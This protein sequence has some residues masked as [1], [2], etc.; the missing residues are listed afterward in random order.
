MFENIFRFISEKLSLTKYSVQSVAG[1]DISA[2]FLLA[3][4]E[5]KYFVKMNDRPFARRV[6][7]EEQ[8][9]LQAI[10]KTGTIN[11]PHV[12]LTDEFENQSFIV[13]EYIRSTYPNS[14]DFE[15]LGIQ[16]AQLHRTTNE[17]FGFS[18][19]NFIGRLPQS[20]RFH[21]DWSEFYWQERILPQLQLCLKAGYLKSDEMP[22]EEKALNVFRKYFQNVTPSLLHGDLWNGNFL[23]GAN[24]RKPYLIDPAVYYGHNMSDIAMTRLFGGFDRTFYEAY[25]QIIPQTDFYNEQIELYQLYYLLVHLN[26]FGL[27][28]RSSV[29]NIMNRYF[30]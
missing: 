16:L 2:A 7:E 8:T 21:S 30:N 12:I 18:S 20:N 15:Q 5:E 25:H 3:S 29:L 22:R 9:G 17:Q 10:E 28:Y 1:G 13:M 19:D 23:I 26:L 24:G 4:K 11:V 6:F 14:K 27:S